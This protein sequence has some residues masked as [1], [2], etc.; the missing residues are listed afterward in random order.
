VAPTDLVNIL[1]LSDLHIYLTVPFVLSWSMLNAMSCGCV[2]L[3]SD[4]A[5][6]REVIEHERTGLLAGFYDVDRFVE[7]ALKVLDDPAAYRPIGQAAEQ[8]IDQHY[9]LERKL[10]EMLQLYEQTVA[11]TFPPA[12]PANSSD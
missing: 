7:L 5:P 8:L 2:V 6:V 12:A 11:G 4:T 3:A 9:S 1:S 10:P